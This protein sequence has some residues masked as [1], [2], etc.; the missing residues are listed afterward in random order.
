VNDQTDPQLLRA[1]AE[2]RSEPAF[3]E[4][5][6]RHV[7]FVHS[8][9][10]RMVCDSHLAQDVTQGVFVALAKNAD[11]IKDHPV[12]SGWLHRTAQNIAAQT[13]RTDV[14][15][16]AR[17][18]EA[19][20][21]NEMLATAPDASWEQIAPQLDAALGE[22][23]EADRDALLLRY[24]ERKSAREM[25]QTLGVS[26]EAAQKRVNRAVER[27]REF[28]AK[29]GVTVGAGGLVVIISANAVQAA[30]AGLATAICAASL[31]G[32]AVATSTVVTAT[33]TIAM[34]TFQKI[35]ITAT[36]AA[37]VGTSLYE[38]RQASLL[39]DQNQALRQRLSPLA[40]Q[41]D[42]LQSE[43]DSA[44][45]RQVS[46]TEQM[47]K[48]KSDNGELLRLRG[49][50]TR[51]R[52]DASRAD[53]PAQ[54]AAK[55]WFNRVA[56]LKQRL[57]QTPG[58]NIPELKL[59]DD[60]DWLAAVK[61]PHLESDVEYRRALST[62]RQA[63]ESKVV[64][65][66]QQGLREFMKNNG[67][68]FPTGLDQLQ[69]YFDSPMDEAILQRWE[70]TSPK[71]VPSLGVGRDYIITQKQAVDD[72]FDTRYA[73]GADGF[74]STDFLSAETRTVMNPVYDAYRAAHNGEW[75]PHQ[76]QLLPYATTPEQQT[77]LQKLI[78][79]DS[80]SN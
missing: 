10:L 8:A 55:Q 67:K 42:K 23:G 51:L 76:S 32:T 33:K 72:V 45:N 2:N 36:I 56:Q 17:E 68:Q 52:A 22:L 43:R 24:F 1:Y 9:A 58:A 39:R 62:L 69:P 34:T 13:V 37:L 26:E 19:A 41:L 61:N 16:R 78:L 38:V 21:M 6:R 70:I 28:F 48:N 80:S 14:R 73:V 25:A 46:L 15:R 11:E 79:R 63:A 12:L 54:T 29:R 71:T 64:S 35:A 77:A 40:E 75:P 47:E 20:T 27:L 44:I 7:D 31:T 49:E 53:D 3:A 50:I 30:P 65:T 4:L 66:F 18:S 60:E 5:V 59:L 57:A 74:G